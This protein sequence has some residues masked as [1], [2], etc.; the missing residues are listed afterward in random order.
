VRLGRV[1]VGHAH[2]QAA[3][4]CRVAVNDAVRA[5]AGVADGER[6]RARG[7]RRK[8]PPGGIASPIS[9]PTDDMPTSERRVSG[10]IMADALSQRGLTVDEADRL[11]GPERQAP[12][13]YERAG[14]QLGRASR[15]NRKPASMIA[16]ASTGK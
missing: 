6:R 14:A 4:P 13:S 12:S 10:R 2:L 16:S 11:R 5:A 7:T 1:D 3:D 15:S 8:R 9:A